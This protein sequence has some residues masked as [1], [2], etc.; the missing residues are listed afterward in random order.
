MK[1]LND[2]E[3]N[4]T[5]VHH[6]DFEARKNRSPNFVLT[7]KRTLIQGADYCD[8]CYYDTQIVKEIEHPTDNFW[9][10]LK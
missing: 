1:E 5:V 4:Y 2:P 6:Y 3:F 8:F 7:R 9:I 10:V